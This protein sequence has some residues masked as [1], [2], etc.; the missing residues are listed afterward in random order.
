[1]IRI[2]SCRH[3]DAMQER[4]S[5]CKKSERKSEKGRKRKKEKGR[6]S[7]KG[8]KRMSEK[9]RKSERKREKGRKKERGVMVEMT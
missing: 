4:K 1:M 6:K 7:E 3:L 2:D 9:G 5:V 8:R